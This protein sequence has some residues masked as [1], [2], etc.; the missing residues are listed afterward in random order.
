MWI[1]PVRW[2]APFGPPGTSCGDRPSSSEYSVAA[3]EY[4]SDRVSDVGGSAS[5]SGAAHGRL[6]PMESEVSRSL[7]PAPTVAY[8]CARAI[9]ASGK[10]S[11]IVEM[12]KSDSTGTP[13]SVSRMFAGLMSRCTIPAR[14]A[15]SSALL[16]RTPSVS[17][18]F[19]DNGKFR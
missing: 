14:C 13:Y 7:A 6:R 5:V 11:S 17:T 4:R 1:R 8:T 2:E 19:T 12:P 16:S 9:V 10:S 3:S 15:A 18:S